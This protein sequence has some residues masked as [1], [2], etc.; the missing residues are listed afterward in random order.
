MSIQQ[1][2]PLYRGP[3]GEMLPGSVDDAGRQEVAI[4]PTIDPSKNFQGNTTGASLVFPKI[5][6][7]RYVVTSLL[8]SVINTTGAASAAITFTLEDDS[9]G[10]IWEDILV[11]P[12]GEPQNIPY[13]N[14]VLFSDIN[15]EMT[16][17][18][19]PAPGA[20]I[21]T[22]INISGYTFPA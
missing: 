22:G 7:E 5:L 6:T 4:V 12:A 13:T 2:V 1:V 21:F 14:V 20:G 11:A 17:S 18:R 16:I 8:V 9:F 19:S 15:A 3:N 10:T